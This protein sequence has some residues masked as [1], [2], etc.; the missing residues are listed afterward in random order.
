[1]RFAL[2]GDPRKQRAKVSLILARFHAHKLIGIQ[3]TYYNDYTNHY[4]NTNELLVHGDGQCGAWAAFFLDMRK[5]QGISGINE[6]VM[7]ESNVATGFIVKNWNFNGSGTS[8]DM[9]YPYWNKRGDPF[10]TATSYHWDSPPT[11]DVTYTSGIQGQG[12]A[13]NLS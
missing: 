7:I 3:L 10:R 1:M 4:M 6:Y 9:T 11:P 2:C 13:E 8:G 5:V 12:D